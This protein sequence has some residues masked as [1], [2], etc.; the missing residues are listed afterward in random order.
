M[1]RRPKLETIGDTEETGTYVRFKADGSVMEVT[2]LNYETLRKRLRELA[3]L[4]GTTGLTLTLHDER[5]N[6]SDEFC[7]PEG[8]KQFVDDLNRGKTAIH[9]DVI[10]VAGEMESTEGGGIYKVEL[11]LAYNDGYNENV[12][13]FVNNINTSE[14][15]THLSGFK[16][17]LTRALN[18]YAK[19][20]KLL[21]AEGD[22]AERRRL[23]RRA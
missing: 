14:G 15:G 2:E 10:T 12:F 16:T 9:K 13:T 17:A 7:F 23:P 5:D 3:Y 21:K 22:S 18:N 19:N 8:L 1:S 4:M 6:S 11:A 20:E